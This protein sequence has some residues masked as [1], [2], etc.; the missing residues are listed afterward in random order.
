MVYV[1]NERFDDYH[2]STVVLSS[3]F[4]RFLS[5][6]FARFP[7]SLFARFL[8]SL[9]ARFPSSLFAP[10]MWTRSHGPGQVLVVSPV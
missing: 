10:L 1:I 9:L 4:A 8:S 3:L 7:S 6:L 5:S 2:S